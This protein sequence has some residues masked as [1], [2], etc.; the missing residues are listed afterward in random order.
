MAVHTPD[1]F[2]LRI[3][4][5]GEYP[6]RIASVAWLVAAEE[7]SSLANLNPNAHDIKKALKEYVNKNSEAGVFIKG[8]MLKMLVPQERINW[9]KDNQRQFYWINHYISELKKSQPKKIRND[10]SLVIHKLPIS[11]PYY[12]SN[13]ERNIALVDYWLAK[14]FFEMTTAIQYCKEMESKW[15]KH[16]ESDKLFSWLEGTD[17]E[18]KRDCFWLFLK[19]KIPSETNDYQKFQ[20]HENL[21]IFFDHPMFT[22][23]TKELYNL[24]ARK[25]WNQRLRREKAKDVKQCNFVLPLK[26]ISKLDKLSK[27]H[28][29]TRTEIIELIINGEAEKETYIRERLS[30]RNLLLGLHE[31]TE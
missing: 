3:D 23:E 16:I 29:L 11:I 30:R 9:I 12:L 31:P 28:H 19:N 20:S 26:T 18:E 27:K 22:R 13:R 21:L 8:N 10:L 24:N 1:N 14:S 6:S 7:D 5:T 15:N 4:S 25:I 17:A 2:S